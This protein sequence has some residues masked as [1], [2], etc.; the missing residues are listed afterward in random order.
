[1]ILGIIPRCEE[2]TV[3]RVRVAAAV[4]AVLVGLS[5]AACSAGGTGNTSAAD[6]PVTSSGNA[7]RCPGKVVDVVV[8]VSQ[9]TDLVRQLGGDCTTVTTVLASSAIDPHDFEPKPGDIAA[10]EKADLVVLN[11]AGY[12]TWGANALE[13]LDPAPA[14]VT[15]ADIVGAPASTGGNRHLWYEP[16]LLPRMAEAVTSELTRL[17]PDDTGTFT[18]QATAWKHDLQPYLD[19]ISAL[20]TAAPG[21]TYAATET[22]FDLTAH[23]IGLTD[24]TPEGY[25]S[26]VSN[27]SDPAPGDIAAFE[28]ALADGKVGVLIFNTQTRGSVPDQ[29]RAAATKAGVPVVEVTESPEDVNG[30]FVAWQLTQLQQLSDALAHIR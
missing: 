1:L 14:V 21:H 15:A 6:R 24:V 27:E 18:A 30:S 7:T 19:K 26:A 3:T 25:R 13:N 29:L 9:W 8:S 5:T 28:S 10:F 11:G 23:A 12:D 4:L 16:D 2:G 20:R 17:A 22:V